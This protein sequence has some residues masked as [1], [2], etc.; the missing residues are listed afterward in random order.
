M[1]VDI[2]LLHVYPQ[3]HWH[4]AAILVG[5]RAGLEAAKR[6]IE[7]AL[8][9]GEGEEEV[10][11]TDGE[12][13]DFLVKM[14]TAEWTASPWSH[15]AVPYSDESIKPLPGAWWACDGGPGKGVTYVAV[16]EDADV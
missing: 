3:S 9:C 13:Y 2:A 11:A 4:E 12:G 5:N 7:R 6:A 1:A 8:A 15:L 10:S 14:E 16:R